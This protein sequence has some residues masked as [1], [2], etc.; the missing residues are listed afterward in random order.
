MSSHEL[1]KKLLALPDL[2]VQTAVRS[3]ADCVWADTSEP[4]KVLENDDEGTS[5]V[6]IEGFTSEPSEFGK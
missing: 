5:Y 3:P 4:V 6:V 2:P 1:A